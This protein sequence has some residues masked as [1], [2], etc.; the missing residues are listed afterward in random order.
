MSTVLLVDDEV[1]VVEVLK[2]VLEVGGHRVVV[3]YNGLDAIEHALAQPPDVI[4]TDMM[5]PVCDGYQLIAQ[6]RA[7]PRTREIPIIA[8]SAGADP[9]HRPFLRKPFGARA[10]LA[11]VQKAVPG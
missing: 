9:G 3:A 5:M 1:D 6:V 8:I 11:E 2:D 7:S 10:L 4:I